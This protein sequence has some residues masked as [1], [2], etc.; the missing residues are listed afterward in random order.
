M[1]PIDRHLLTITL[2]LGLVLSAPAAEPRPTATNAPNAQMKAV[3]D[4]LAALGG[5][6]IPSL[7]PGEARRQPTATD[8]V[9]ALLKKQGKSTDPEAVG[10]VKLVEYRGGAGKLPARVYTPK[11]DGPFPVLV[12]WHG[13]GWVL[14]DLDTYDASCRAL[15]NAAECVVVSC[16]YRHAPE[17]PYPAAADDA[18]AAYEWVL[19]S[20]GGWKGDSK[21]V[22][23]G[24]ESAGGN[25]AAVTALRA[26]DK[27]IQAPVHQLLIYPVTDTNF[28]TESYRENAEAKPLNRAMMKWFWAHY[29]GDR[30]PT[31][32][33]YAMP[34]QAA[35]LSKLPPAT[36]ITAQIDPLRSEGRA[37]ADKL[38][39]AGVKVSYR[40]YEG[41]TH[42]F[43]GM[44][45]VLDDAKR[46]V[47]QA[48]E[49]LKESFRK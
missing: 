6:P 20:A 11:G 40:N 24:G 18:F 28:D 7:T 14:A 8:A 2:G 41:V 23:I 17:D 19:Q 5:K 45:A 4:Q 31:V 43:F 15:C 49:G 39:K 3:L 9:M 22:A 10:G 38:T 29:V 26:R 30:L 32:N 48:A 36:I 44:G 1:P 35:D 13:G 37:Y 34:F 12:Y 21:R 47:A 33:P 27:G 42:E 46:A 25:L 16:E